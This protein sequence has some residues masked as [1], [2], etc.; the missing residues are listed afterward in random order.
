MPS[1]ATTLFRDDATGALAYYVPPASFCDGLGEASALLAEARREIEAHY[2]DRD[3]PLAATIDRRGARRAV[4]RDQA[5][6]GAR[7]AS[8]ERAAGKEAS[9]SSKPWR[10]S[11]RYN[12][13]RTLQPTPASPPRVIR[14]VSRRVFEVCGQTCNHAVVN[15]YRDGADAIGAH[16]DKATDLADGSFVVSVSLGAT[17][18]MVFEPRATKKDRE[19]AGV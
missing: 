17:R 5:Y 13:D 7:Y 3:D 9:V 2:L 10:A 12:P 1:G 8:R 15:R 11:Y 18:T 6:F 4:P 16:A 19:G 14:A